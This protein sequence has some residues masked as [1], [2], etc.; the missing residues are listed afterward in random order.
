MRRVGCGAAEWGGS[1]RLGGFRS[2]VL[3]SSQTP[4]DCR[5]ELILSI[6]YLDHRFYPEWLVLVSQSFTDCQFS[7]LG[8]GSLFHAVVVITLIVILDLVYLYEHSQRFL[9]R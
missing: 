2:R 3:C 9:P 5:H 4:P 1:L 7:A 8:A 6:H